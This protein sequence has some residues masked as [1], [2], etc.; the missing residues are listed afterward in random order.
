MK[1]T[2]ELKT[3]QLFEVLLHQINKDKKKGCSGLDFALDA[4]RMYKGTR[5]CFCDVEITNVKTALENLGYRVRYSY[6][7][8]QLG[9]QKHLTIDW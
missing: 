7:P 2:T 6:E 3:K 4:E 8:S 9:C 5:V 1:M